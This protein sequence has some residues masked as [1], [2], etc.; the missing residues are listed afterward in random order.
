[1]RPAQS[2][3]IITIANGQEVIV[4]SSTRLRLRQIAEITGG[5]YVPLGQDGQ[6]L[7]EVYQR[8]IAPLPKANLEERR[9]KIHIEQ[10]EWPLAAATFLLMFQ[11]MIK[12]GATAPTVAPAGRPS[13]HRR[14]ARHSIGAASLIAFA[15]LVLPSRA[16]RCRHSRARLQIWQVRGCRAALRK[17]YRRRSPPATTCNTIAAM[18]PTRR[19]IFPRR[20]KPIA[21]RWR[22][23]TSAC[24][25]MPTTTWATR[26]SSTAMRC[27]RSI[28]RRRSSCGSKRST[29]TI[30]R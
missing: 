14:R 22:R 15:F 11:F 5:A 16:R 26:Y 19:A 1:M 3:F 13:P 28:P 4:A 30:P 20:R 7:D 6:G 29:P 25:R 10:F 24:R 12:D 18:P 2:S 27:R 8:Y 9:E 21:K 23:P 17:G